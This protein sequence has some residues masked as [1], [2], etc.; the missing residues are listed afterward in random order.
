MAKDTTN[1]EIKI[2]APNIREAKFLIRGTAPLVVHKFSAKAKAMIRQKQEAGS[3]ANKGKSNT[4]NAIFL[5]MTIFIV[6]FGKSS[7]NNVN[8]KPFLAISAEKA[9]MLTGIIDSFFSFLI[10][11]YIHNMLFT[12][13]N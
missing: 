2:S 5:F 9:E 1:M 8:C 11:I 12:M 13:Q 6:Q 7:R 3:L 10:C 4:R